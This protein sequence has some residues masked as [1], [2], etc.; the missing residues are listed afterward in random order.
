MSNNTITQL[1]QK[2]LALHRAG[3]RREAMECYVKV[4]KDNPENADALYY[5]AVI[6][7]QEDQLDNGVKLAQR[8]VLFAPQQARIHNVLGQGL[9]RLGRH[10][11]ALASFERAI[12]LK[13]DFA[14]AHGNRANLLAEL[15]R[16]GEALI[17]F[18]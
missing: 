2:G 17:A 18:D 16:P 8:A 13:P 1:L 11:E 6:S 14:D 7:L 4:L 9:H 12:D 10:S 5:V 15:G 3:M